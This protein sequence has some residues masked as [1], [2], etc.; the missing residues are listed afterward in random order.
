M[1]GRDGVPA[2]AP[3]RSIP[4]EAATELARREIARLGLR[5]E[6]R[7]LGP[8]GSSIPAV[9]LWRQGAPV[10]AGFGKGPDAAQALAS[11]HFEAIESYFAA[12]RSARR[13]GG[14]AV[15]VRSAADIATQ[16]ELRADRVIRRFAAE[17]PSAGAACAVYAAAAGSTVRYPVFLIDP[18]YH[19]A[20]VAGD[21]V[22]EY[23]GLLRYTSSVGT[24]A[25]ADRDEA[26]LHGLCELVEHDAF[27]H[28]L[29]RWF[30]A[31]S[32]DFAVVDPDTL[33][34]PLRAD[35]ADAVRAAGGEIVLL[36]VTTD[37]GIPV[38]LAVHEPGGAARPALLGAGASPLAWCAAQR[39]LTELV[40]SCA[41]PDLERET[42]ALQRLSPWPALRDCLRLPIAEAMAAG[43]IRGVRLRGGRAQPSGVG[44]ALA[45][46]TTLLAGHGIVVYSRLLTPPES[47][48]A[49]A[50][51]IAPGLER[52][53]LVRLGFPVVPTGRGW[54]IWDLART[55]IG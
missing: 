23:G 34:P 44:L 29:L 2:I 39:A 30:I 35:H 9:R 32:R 24:A 31:G 26:V 33:P 25:G 36:D 40:Q 46:L 19:L 8:P 45:R 49:V 55:A 20:P 52:F 4:A 54:G 14:D 47:L 42:L 51:V 5:A 6:C 38:Y 53:S 27:S 50:T 17:F 41:G 7:Q 15:A 16:P 10:A 28:A 48:V 11:A 18:R 3:D 22:A 43:R 1:D 12:D 21:T 37:L 13:P